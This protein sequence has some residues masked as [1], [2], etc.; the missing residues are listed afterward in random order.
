MH[1]LRS[2]PQGAAHEM[3]RL[4]VFS[5]RWHC[6]RLRRPNHPRHCV[7]SNCCRGARLEGG[8]RVSVPT[9]DTAKF[10][11]L[12]KYRIVQYGINAFMIQRRFCGLW[13]DTSDYMQRSQEKCHEIL[14]AWQADKEVRGRVVWP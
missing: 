10:P 9:L 3:V 12:G 6:V 1:L 7:S 14:L 13:F 8:I 5:G 11:G 2:T 4:L